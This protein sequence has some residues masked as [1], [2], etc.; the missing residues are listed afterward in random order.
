MDGSAGWV[1]D[2]GFSVLVAGAVAGGGVGGG[3]EGT[4]AGVGHS[5]DVGRFR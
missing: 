3:L 1:G 4:V 2:A 5:E